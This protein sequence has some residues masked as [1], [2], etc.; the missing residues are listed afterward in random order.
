[1]H[2][3]ATDSNE[4]R[5]VPLLLAIASVLCALA[6]N[7]LQIVAQFQ[8]PWWI[9]APSVVGFYALFYAIFDNCLW[10]MPILRKIGIVNLPDLRGKWKGHI[11]SSLDGHASQH[12]TTVNIRQSWSRASIELWTETSESKSLSATVLTENRNAIEISYEYLNEPKADAAKTM[13]THRGTTRLTLS[14]DRRKLEGAYYTGRDRQSFGV[15][16]VG[17]S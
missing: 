9:D 14:P 13:H 17:R 5:S 15:L 12:G 4:R 1:M 8:L 11:A 2:A 3:Y 7:R 6:L 16:S 10:R